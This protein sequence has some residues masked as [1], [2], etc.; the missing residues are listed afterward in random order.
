[1]SR[2]RTYDVTEFKVSASLLICWEVE[3]LKF[4]PHY[5]MGVSHHLRL[6][7]GY[8]GVR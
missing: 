5:K 8:E 2:E 7:G 4:P 3:T 6:G 1:M